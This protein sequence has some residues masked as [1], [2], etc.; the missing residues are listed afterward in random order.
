MS[1]RS[2]SLVTNA[3]ALLLFAA[4]LAKLLAVGRGGRDVDLANPIF[5]SRQ[6]YVLVALAAAEFAIAVFLV[7]SANRRA[8]HAAL[9][10]VCGCFLLYRLA[11]ALIAPGVPC[12]CFGKGT[13]DRLPWPREISENALVIGLLLA[14]VNS[15][16]EARRREV[17]DSEGLAALLHDEAIPSDQTCAP[18]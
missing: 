14:L 5:A 4:S 9:A 3:F 12:D 17:R 8:K 1:S 10:W 18:G 7:A 13:L 16:L 11:F 6:A 2:Q 15:Y